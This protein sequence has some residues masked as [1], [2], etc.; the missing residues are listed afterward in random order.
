MRDSIILYIHTYIIII[1]IIIIIINLKI[2]FRQI[3][4]L[5]KVTVFSFIDF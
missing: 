2:L 3:L 4:N 5:K 1:I